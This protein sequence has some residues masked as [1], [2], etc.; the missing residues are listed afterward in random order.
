MKN[1]TRTCKGE[2]GRLALEMRICCIKG[3]AAVFDMS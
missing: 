2:E 3:E 1:D